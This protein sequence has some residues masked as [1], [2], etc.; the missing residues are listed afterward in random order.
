MIKRH[1]IPQIQTL[2][3]QF[4]VVGIVG[5]R[6]VGKTTLAKDLVKTTNKKGL[7]LDLELPSDL[8]LLRDAELFF[9]EHL[10]TQLVLD[11]IHHKPDLFPVMRSLIDL[12]RKPGRFLVTGSASP[13]VIQHGSE[14]LAGRIAFCELH[15][16]SITETNDDFKKLWLRGGFPDSYLAKSMGDSMRWRENFIQTYIQRD[17]PS[18]GLV[19]NKNTLRKLLQMIAHSQGSVV[20]YSSLSKSLGISVTTIINYVEVLE[21]TFVIRKL[22]AYHTNIKKRL[23]KASKLFI[24]DTGL[25]HSLWGADSIRGL[26]SH[27]LVG[28]SWEGFVIQQ[29]AAHLKGTYEMFYYRTQDGAEVDLVITKSTKPIV[30]IEIKFSDNPVLSK[31]N[32]IALADLKAKYNLIIT[33]TAKDHAYDKNSRV[34]SLPTALTELNKL[35]LLE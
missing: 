32:H 18:L 5:P 33:P 10:D 21:D 9:K 26:L 14:T 28:H 24:R 8:N 15:P 12:K 31:G 13:A 23:V 25:L 35:G 22:P 7:Y 1:I 19:A 27:H 20:N 34:F 30:S 2:L 16:F 29:I 4:P 17:V 3:K 6:Q 11:E